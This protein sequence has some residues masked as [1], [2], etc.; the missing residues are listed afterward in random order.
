MAVQQRLMEIDL[1]QFLMTVV[2]FSMA[3]TPLLAMFGRRIKSYLYISEVLHDNKLKREIGDIEKHVVVVGFSMVGRIATY[4]MRKNGVRHI[5]LENNHRIVQVERKK[6]HNIYYGDAM[7]VDILRY[8]GVER[9]ESVV[10]VMEDEIACMKISRFI[11]E[12]F[13]HVTIITKTDT[14]N[15]IDR[16]KRVGANH[17]ISKNLETGLQL[18]NT[19]L[20]SAGVSS[21]EISAAINSFR[22]INPEI[23]KEIIAID[24]ESLVKK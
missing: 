17:V 16:F 14:V 20:T 7:N 10:V 2:T 13:P 22:A 21:I 23:I 24:D 19:A 4:I 1:A 8:I 6:G 15:N 5:V 12:N 9:C 18:I 11:R 3:L